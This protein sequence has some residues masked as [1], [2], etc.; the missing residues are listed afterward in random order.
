MDSRFSALQ[1]YTVVRLQD[2]NF[3][4]TFGNNLLGRYG[5]NGLKLYLSCSNLFFYAPYWEGSDPEIRNFNA[6]QLQRTLTFG[7]NFKF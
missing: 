6:A 4:Y 7:L 2:V 1:A 3:S 5:I